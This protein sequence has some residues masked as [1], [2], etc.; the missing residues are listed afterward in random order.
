M[1]NNQR[2][3]QSKC[4]RILLIITFFVV[5][6]F[7]I[8]PTLQKNSFFPYKFKMH[9][10]FTK[11]NKSKNVQTL[12]SRNFLKIH[13]K[14][15]LN[16]TEKKV[17]FYRVVGIGYGNRIYSMLSAFLAAIISDSALLIDWPL[18]D[19]FIES[20]LVNVFKKYTDKSF[21]DFNQTTPQIC[22]IITFTNN[23]WSF[24]KQFDF[25]QGNFFI[26]MF[27]YTEFGRIPGEFWATSGNFPCRVKTRKL[28]KGTG[29]ICS[30]SH[31]K[32]FFSIF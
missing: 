30:K 6:T 23:T 14:I 15:V 11:S 22:T 3:V 21:L 7:Y 8:K 12:K 4:L 13:E 16:R 24:N 28:F 32:N 9:K 29:R 20:P 27:R 26:V 18:I 5:I 19:N 2:Y 25:L 17:V 10:Y 1:E 31:E